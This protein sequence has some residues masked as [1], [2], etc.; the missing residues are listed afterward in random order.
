[1]MRYV[2]YDAAGRQTSLT[3]EISFIREYTELMKLRIGKKTTVLLQIQDNVTDVLIAPMVFLP[4]IENAFKH[5]V[6]GIAEGYISIWILQ[7]AGSVELIVKNTVYENR[8]A[9]EEDSNGI[10][11]L[12]TTR[13]LDLLY[14][15]KYTLSA[16]LIGETEYQAKLKLIL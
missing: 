5:G 3:K 11:I 14:P 13:R 2:L 4:F 10:G 7:D 9:S 6:S 15:G 12:N 8:P 1:M 16:G